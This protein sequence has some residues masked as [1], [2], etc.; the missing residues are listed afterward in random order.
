MEH[1]EREITEIQIKTL[2]LSRVYKSVNDN[3][4]VV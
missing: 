4:L 3:D 2:H 1:P